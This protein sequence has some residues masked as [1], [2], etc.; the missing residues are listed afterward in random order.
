MSAT[1]LASA[2]TITENGVA[3]PFT[4]LQ[5]KD[6][7]ENLLLKYSLLIRGGNTLT[8]ASTYV[9]TITPAVTDFADQPLG[10]NP[11]SFSFTTVP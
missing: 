3:V 10:G 8:K 11:I 9:V 5:E 7:S 2:V 6:A 1:S 4:V